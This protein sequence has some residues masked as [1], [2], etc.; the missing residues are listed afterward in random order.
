MTI[1]GIGGCMALMEVGFGLRDSIM[2]I[3]TIQYQEL[4]VYDGMVYL[5]NSVTDEEIRT[6]MNTMDEMGKM[7]RYMEM[8]MM[9]EPIAA[10]ADGKTEDVYLCVPED[11]DMVDEFMTFRDRTSGE[12][13]HLTDDGVILTEKM[14]KT[15]DCR[16]EHTCTKER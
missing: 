9:K 16:E 13:Y 6:I 5:S 14:A 15:E 10:S 12:I 7:D 8:E 1:A 2:C 3:G 4:Q 11:K